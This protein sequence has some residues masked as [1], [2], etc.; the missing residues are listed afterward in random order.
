MTAKANDTTNTN[1]IEEAKLFAREV[2]RETWPQA[3]EV[4]SETP[5]M[6][7][8]DAIDV[9]DESSDVSAVRIMFDESA[10]T[11]ALTEELRSVPQI[12][13]QAEH[14]LSMADLV[15]KMELRVMMLMQNC[16]SD[17]EV[18][19]AWA[20]VTAAASQS[21]RIRLQ[22]IGGDVDKVMAEVDQYFLLNPT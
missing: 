19:A 2:I 10:Y 9:L 5:S 18:A 15:S 3:R 13:R 6:Y 20:A 21:A 1:A 4:E 8:F 22:E 11:Y 12:M 14:E 17:N 7:L 16:D